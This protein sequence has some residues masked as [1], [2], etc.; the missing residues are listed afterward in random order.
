MFPA[1]FSAAI[2][3]SIFLLAAKIISSRLRCRDA[4]RSFRL[5]LHALGFVEDSGSLPVLT[6]SCSLYLVIKSGSAGFGGALKGC[7]CVAEGLG[8]VG[9]GDG[10]N[11]IGGVSIRPANIRSVVAA[12]F[13][14]LRCKSHKIVLRSTRSGPKIC[15]ILST[16]ASLA[17]DT[18]WASRG[19]REG[20]AGDEKNRYRMMRPP[21][22]IMKIREVSDTCSSAISVASAT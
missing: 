19:G 13:P 9:G 1:D 15:C 20:W 7:V 6:L 17:R 14:P 11:V 16:A 5:E 12:M 8:E 22:T 18:A 21:R 10:W 2:L 3:A 4:C